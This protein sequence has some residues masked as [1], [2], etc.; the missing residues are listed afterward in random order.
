MTPTVDS[1]G[2]MDVTSV[3]SGGLGLSLDANRAIAM[4]LEVGGSQQQGLVIGGSISYMKIGPKRGWRV[5]WGGRVA[6]LEKNIAPRIFGHYVVV[7][8]SKTKVEKALNGKSWF[9][10]RRSSYPFLSIGPELSLV[11]D[12]SDKSVAIGLSLRA[13]WF[14]VDSITK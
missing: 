7:I 5:G 10:M 4:D 14:L 3:A 11:G 6:P 1:K 12:R 13:A 8:R 9:R 2:K